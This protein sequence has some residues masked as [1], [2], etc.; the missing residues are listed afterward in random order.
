MRV[1]MNYGRKMLRS[2]RDDTSGKAASLPA[3]RV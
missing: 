1:G 3:E 2:Y